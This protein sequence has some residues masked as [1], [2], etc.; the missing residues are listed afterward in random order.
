MGLDL[1]A[2]FWACSPR[3]RS[4]CRRSGGAPSA[5]PR[6][7]VD[8]DDAARQELRARARGVGAV[9]R[10]LR[11]DAALRG[12]VPHHRLAR[13]RADGRP[14]AVP[15]PGDG[16]RASAFPRRGSARASATGFPVSIGAA[17]FGAGSL[18]YIARDGRAA[19]LLLGVPSRDADHRRRRGARDP[20]ADRGGGLLAGARALRDGRGGPDDGPPDRA[21]LGVAMLV[22]VLGTGADTVATSTPRGWSP[23]LAALASGATLAALGPRCPRSHAGASRVALRA[24]HELGVRSGRGPSAGRTRPRRPPQGSSCRALSTCA[25]S[26]DG[27][28]AAAAD[29][30]ACSASLS[31]RPSSGRAVFAMEP[32][33]W[34]CNPIGGVHGGIA[35]TIL[36]SC[37]GCAVHTTLPAGVGYR[38][39]R[40]AGPLHPPDRPPGR[41]RAGGGDRACTPAGA[42]RRPRGGSSPRTAGAL[43]A[44]ASTGCAIFP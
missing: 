16:G 27:D 9:L 3:P 2:A 18:W 21:A 22:A 39:D 1:R 12:P 37:M 25:R 4:C 19:R 6:P 5:T 17:L 11:R 31:A 42:P 8:P 44:H 15:G 10:G 20:D 26:R 30:D 13:G 14:D 41:P 35:A 40:P 43:L 32:A 34:M 38:D 29:R 7:I 36:D 23:V 33:E 28:P 24:R